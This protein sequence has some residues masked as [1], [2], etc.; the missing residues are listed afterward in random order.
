MKREHYIPFDKEF[1]LE[2]QIEAFSDDTKKVEDFKKLFDIIEHYYHYEAFNL[3]RDLKHNYAAFNPITLIC[4]KF[5]AN[6]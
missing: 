4:N 5:L 3:M 2:Q 6:G 1:L